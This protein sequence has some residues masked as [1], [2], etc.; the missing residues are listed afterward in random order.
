MPDRDRVVRR[1]GQDGARR[2]VVPGPGVPEP[3]GGQD[4]Q[5]G[6]LGPGI[7]HRDLHQEVI[8]ACLGVMDLGNPVTPGIESAGVDQLVFGVEAAPGRVLRDE[9]LVGIGTLGIVVTPAV[10]RVGGGGVQVPPV[11]LD[12][13]TVVAL[14]AGQAEWP[15][16]QYRVAAIPERQAQAEALLDIAEAGQGVLAPPVGTR[17]GVVVREIV[18][19]LAVGAVVLADRAPLTLADVGPPPVPVARLAQSILQVAQ[20][21]DP[22]PLGTQRRPLPF[23]LPRKQHSCCQGARHHAG[24][25][26]PGASE[27]KP[28]PQPPG[29]WLGPWALRPQRAR[30]GAAVSR[31]DRAARC[32]QEGRYQ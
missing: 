24:T 19:G 32:G 16:F 13:L 29:G 4:V 22:L 23:S 5:G 27:I 10:P 1:R 20:P 18:P 6:L 30:P 28:R 14:R 25:P 21:A 9:V 12:V 26:S 8:R 3:G 17:P 31:R 15:F 7:G 11:F 2:P